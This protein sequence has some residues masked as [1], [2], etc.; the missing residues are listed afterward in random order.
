MTSEPAVFAI[1]LDS[2]D[3]GLARRLMDTGVMPNLGSLLRL[4]KWADVRSVADIGSGAVWP[5]FVTGTPPHVH[6]RYGEW[7]WNP[8]DMDVQ[9]FS[10]EGLH[11]FWEPLVQA[12]VPVGILDVPFAPFLEIHNGFEI[13]E[14]GAHDVLR[15]STLSSPRA[16]TEIVARHEPHPFEHEPPI[17]ESAYRHA[18]VQLVH[19]VSV[20]GVHR[21]GELLRD[22]IVQGEP[23][24]VVAVFPEFHHAAH[25]LWHALEPNHPLYQ[26]ARLQDVPDLLDVCKALDTELGRLVE[27]MR[28][29]DSILVFSLHGMRACLGIPDLMAPLLRQ[30]HLASRATWSSRT[31][32]ERKA[33]AF[34]EIKRRSPGWMK[35][36]YHRRTSLMTQLRLARSTMQEQHDWGRTQAIALP[37]DQHGWARV[38][39][40]GRE[41]KGIVDAG[42][43]SALCEDIKHM[44]RNSRTV[45][46]ESLVDDV[47]IPL[48]GDDPTRFPLPDVVV[49]WSDAA[50]ADD[51]RLPDPDSYSPKV[52]KARTGQHNAQ[53]FCIATGRASER[54]GSEVAT[55]DLPS[56]ILDCLK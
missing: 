20:E 36:V 33:W 32:P 40:R 53:G 19:E 26:D 3:A 29:N 28:D 42:D 1:G 13:N 38:N 39:L 10:D 56:I 34:S 27:R 8:T 51:L 18:D 37:T 6:G 48:D 49:H 7:R 46:G 50:L 21:R 15:G 16:A 5:T 43:Y 41:S 23:R 31:W 44:A 2:F 24:L 17:P 35:D 14:W 54:L 55:E 45:E 11:P 47:L 9:R 22:L 12:N 52:G 4:G 30:S 25:Y